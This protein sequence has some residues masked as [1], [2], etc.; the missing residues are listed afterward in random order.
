MKA[1]S[2]YVSEYLIIGE[3]HLV[4]GCVQELAYSY[5]NQV[6]IPWAAA[7]SEHM[8]IIFT[9]HKHNDMLYNCNGFKLG[10]LIN[11]IRCLLTILNFQHSSRNDAPYDSPRPAMPWQSL[12]VGP[13][14]LQRI[15]MPLTMVASI[16]PNVRWR[17]KNESREYDRHDRRG[18]EFLRPSRY[19]F[20]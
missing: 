5:R 19:P 18:T 8:H 14:V 13:V 20:P 10:N 11:L 1:C 15:S 16:M 17:A 9:V 7:I 12:G 3:V 2:Y 4:L 6:A